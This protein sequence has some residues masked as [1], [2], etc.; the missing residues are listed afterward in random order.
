MATAADFAGCVQDPV[1]AAAGDGVG[2]TVSI[3]PL[4]RLV[5]LRAPSEVGH[6]R[7][8]ARAH[9]EDALSI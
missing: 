5:H 8:Y 9:D 2:G 4:C 7:R 6:P 3:A 1:S